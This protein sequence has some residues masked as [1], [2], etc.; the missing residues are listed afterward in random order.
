MQTSAH[1]AA[2]A[3]AR[4]CCDGYNED[5]TRD[6]D[7]TSDPAAERLADQAPVEAELAAADTRS[8][9]DPSRAPRSLTAVELVA[10]DEAIA[11]LEDW[12]DPQRL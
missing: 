2:W 12:D 8:G 7:L 10:D 3:G 6:R 5:M 4:A 1:G 11:S 9:G